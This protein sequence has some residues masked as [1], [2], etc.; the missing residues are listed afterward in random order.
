MPGLYTAHI[1]T[2]PAGRAGLALPFTPT[3]GPLRLNN[4]AGLQ[5]VE[6]SEPLWGDAQQYQGV[7]TTG[8]SDCSAI[9]IVEWAGNHWGRFYFEHVAGSDVTQTIISRARQAIGNRGP[10][11]FA[12]VAQYYGGTA[13]SAANMLFNVLGIANGA[14]S[15][16]RSN[17]SGMD[18][19][20]R[21]SGGEFG[22][23]ETA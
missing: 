23:Y 6:M 21:F 11:C 22:E 4:R 7:Y 17:L 1:R 12:V 3:T 8:I 9:A 14:R 18:F 10:R 20:L 5:K 19:G 13:F 15:Y 2:N 16:Y